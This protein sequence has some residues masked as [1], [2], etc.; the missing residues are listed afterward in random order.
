MNQP[1]DIVEQR[2]DLY[3]ASE[4]LDA[5][6]FRYEGGTVDAL[7]KR[8]RKRADA[9]HPDYLA[10][11]AAILDPVQDAEPPRRAERR[12]GGAHPPTGA[13]VAQ[14]AEGEVAATIHYDHHYGAGA[15]RELAPRTKRRLIFRMKAALA[16][17]RAAT[18]P[19][20]PEG[21]AEGA[22]WVLVPREPI[23]EMWAAGGDAQMKLGDLSAHHHDTITSAIYR[24]MIAAAPPPPSAIPAADPISVCAEPDE[25]RSDQPSA[26]KRADAD[27]SQ[28][29]A[30][31]ALPVPW[32]RPE[33]ETAIPADGEAL[34]AEVNRRRAARRFAA[35]PDHIWDWTDL[36]LATG[37]A[38]ALTKAR[39]IL[40]LIGEGGA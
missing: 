4:Y 16:A 26:L 6:A 19:A 37:L 2:R 13:N 40:A 38:T 12:T 20:Q 31:R 30:A 9:L 32:D 28:E 25:P 23:R 10:Q 35:L 1:E 39:A 27:P 17:A 24:A 8:L 33:T 3:D 11:G 5:Q 21:R 22:E 7:A 29:Q 15:F 34:M 18:P 14:G 36:A